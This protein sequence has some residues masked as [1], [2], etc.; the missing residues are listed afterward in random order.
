M[1]M[2]IATP[3]LKTGITAWLIFIAVHDHRTH[4]IPAW[5]TWPVIFALAGWWWLAAGAWQVAASLG[6]I[7]V[8]SSVSGREG[9]VTASGLVLQAL[10]MFTRPAVPVLTIIVTWWLLYLLWRYMD[11]GGGDTAL[12][13][14]LIALFPSPWF[15][16]ILAVV[17]VVLLTPLLIRER[18]SGERRPHP[19]GPVFAAAGIL[20]AWLLPVFPLYM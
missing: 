7:L 3:V 9:M 12:L 17:S 13:M 20:S 11:F 4:R 10:V 19:L 5:S 18:R 8:M 1:G 6:L 15:A 2:D 16:F 14:G